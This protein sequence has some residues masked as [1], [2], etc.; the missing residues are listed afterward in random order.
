MP[1]TARTTNIGEVH[2]QTGVVDQFSFNG[3]QHR[4]GLINGVHY[5]DRVMLDATNDGPQDKE[6][7]DKSGFG[8]TTRGGNGIVLALGTGDNF[9]QATEQIFMQFAFVFMANIVREIVLDKEL[10]PRHRVFYPLVTFRYGSS[11]GVKTYILSFN[12]SAQAGGKVCQFA[13]KVTRSEFLCHSAIPAP[14]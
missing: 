11:R 5:D 8:F 9:R 14:Y 3:F 12:G 2:Q 7:T 1:H 6:L 4:I 10:I 13:G